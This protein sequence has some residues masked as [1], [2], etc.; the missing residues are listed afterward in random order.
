M[1]RRDGSVDWKAGMLPAGRWDGAGMLF[2]TT[3]AGWK[4][5]ILLERQD[6]ASGWWGGIMVPT[7]KVG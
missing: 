5:G 4:G 1:E 2:S 7:G 6:E 3:G